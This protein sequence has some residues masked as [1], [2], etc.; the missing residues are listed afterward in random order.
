MRFTDLHHVFQYLNLDG[1]TLVSLYLLKIVAYILCL[2]G[3]SATVERVFS[4]VNDIWSID[5]ARL[6]IGT[7]RD[8]LYVRYNMKTSCLEFFEFLK[9][10]PKMLEEIGSDGK[11]AFKNRD[12]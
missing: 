2:P 8:L 4:L 12:K 6:S 3:T 10:Q 9:G 5:K 1:V 7:L 11:Y